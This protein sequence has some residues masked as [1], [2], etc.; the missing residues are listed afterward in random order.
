MSK[1]K[2]G[3]LTASLIPL[4]EDEQIALFDWADRQLH[5]YPE[6]GWMFAVNNGLRL[7]PATAIRARKAGT[8]KGVADVCLPAPR[9][10]YHGLWIEMK[11]RVGGR[12]E[13]EQRSFGDAMT[14]QGYLYKVCNG[15]EQAA[16]EIHA[17]LGG[18]C[19]V[20]IPDRPEEL[21][22]GMQVVTDTVARWG[23]AYRDTQVMDVT[24]GHPRDG[25]D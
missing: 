21:P 22:P 2:P 19:Y 14:R 17:Y 11:R 8:R 23:R 1:R 25:S 20:R 13:P 18:Q 4:E 15:W 6:L 10:G 24:M 3:A 7:R 16:A 9:G 12:L 5:K